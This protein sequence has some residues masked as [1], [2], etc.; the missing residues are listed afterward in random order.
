MLLLQALSRQ[1]T[2]W[3]TFFPSECLLQKKNYFLSMQIFFSCN[4]L[5]PRKYDRISKKI[6][7]KMF[8][9]KVRMMLWQPCRKFVAQSL[10]YISRCQSEKIDKF[11]FFSKI[12]WNV[13]LKISFENFSFWIGYLC[14]SSS[15]QQ[16]QFWAISGPP[17]TENI[18]ALLSIS[19]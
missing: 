1:S 14:F 10:L 11:S 6:E 7:P 19:L 18:A 12:A 17:T 13:P 16:F 8:I 3:N 5:I 9:W 2:Y 15:F 4:F